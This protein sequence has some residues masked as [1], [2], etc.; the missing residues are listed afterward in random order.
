MRF[1][2]IIV[3]VALFFGIVVAGLAAEHDAVP[4]KNWPVPFDEIIGAAEA[5]RESVRRGSFL[6]AIDAVPSAASHF[7]A[8]V[9][10]RV[11]D[12]RNSGTPLTTGSTTTIDVAGS[13]CGVPAGASAY[14]LNF[15][16]MNPADN[17]YVTAYPAGTI[18]P[19]TATVSYLAG[20]SAFDNAAIVPAGA[21]GAIDAYVAAQLHLVLDINGYFAEGVVTS[22][23]AGTGLTTTGATGNVTLSLAASTITAAHIAPGEVVLLGPSSRQSKSTGNPLI[24]LRQ[25]GSGPLLRLRTTSSSVPGNPGY[26]VDADQFTV[27]AD[28]GVLARGELGVGVI[29]MTGAGQRLMWYPY[30]GAFRAGYAETEWDDANI[31]FYSWAGGNLTKASVYGSFAFGDQ[32]VVSG[33]DAAA[34]GA[35]NTVSG[36]AAFAAGASHSVTGFTG[37]ALGYSNRAL[38]QGS[39]AVGYRVSA[40]GNYT[41]ALGFRASTSS[42]PTST[43]Q[44]AGTVHTG[45]F[46]WA[47]QSVSTSYFGTAASNEF[48]IRAAGG[49]RLRTNSTATTGCNLPAGSGTFACTSDRNLKTTFGVLDGEEV[50]RK[51]AAIPIGTWSFITEPGVRHAGPVAQDFHHAFGL[52]ADDRSVGLTD[53]AGIALRAVQALEERTR[54]LR[55]AQEA[56]HARTAELEAKEQHLAETTTALT[57][58]QERV[59][60]LERLLQPR[61]GRRD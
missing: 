43:D 3:A 45:A 52:G 50:L 39:S 16:V 36:T 6:P 23:A 29:P 17:G 13:G 5:R 41:T 38:G 30:K 20:G 58:L 56:L 8:I 9:P 37:V 24:D 42:A 18:R 49:V 32:V 27:L 11:L 14:S 15:T 31:G 35:S 46:V 1:T 47:D 44:C 60:R 12:T 55:L 21:G 26:A 19:T 22:I 40:C 33:V 51:L 48:A 28:G 2:N 7:V 54:E 53:L 4:L 34:F 59:D 57:D 61:G 10:C 25:T